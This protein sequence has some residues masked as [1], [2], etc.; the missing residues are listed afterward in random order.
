MVGGLTY[1]VFG[2]GT[3]PDLDFDFVFAAP[4]KFD[5]TLVDL[6]EDPDLKSLPK[7]TTYPY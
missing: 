5:S 1:A 3:F 2:N 7:V 6:D 4:S